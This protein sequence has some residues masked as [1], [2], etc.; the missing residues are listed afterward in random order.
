L[1]EE[2]ESR[3]KPQLAAIP[4]NIGSATYFNYSEICIRHV[5]HEVAITIILCIAYCMTCRCYY[6]VIVS[7][8]PPS[9]P[10]LPLPLAG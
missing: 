1:I 9:P 10:P 3:T 6:I 5:C 7:S 8:P 2:T 4:G